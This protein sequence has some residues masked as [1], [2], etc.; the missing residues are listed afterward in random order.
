MMESNPSLKR[1]PRE[2]GGH[3]LEAVRDA[4]GHSLRSRG[5]EPAWQD[6]EPGTAAVSAAARPR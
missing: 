5:A 3:G 2:K 6:D 1:I 4:G